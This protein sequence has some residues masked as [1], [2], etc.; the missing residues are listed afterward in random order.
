MK[1]KIVFNAYPASRWKDTTPIGNG[2]LGGAIYGATYDE[3][4]L[5]NHEALYDDSINK[6]IPDISYALADVRRLMDEKRYL[7]ADKYY[8]E[9]LKK[10]EY[11][12]KK[13]AFY[14][15]F[16]LHYIL[17]TE[18]AFTDYA[19]KLDMRTG[20]CAVTYKENDA[21]IVR[22]AFVSQKN[23][24]MLLRIE[25]SKSFDVMFALEPHDVTD[26]VD[27]LG[28]SMEKIKDFTSCSEDKYV[29][30]T[31]ETL[32]G[33]HYSGIFSV[34]ETDG[35][36]T[37]NGR[38]KF[39]KIDMHGT[40]KLSNYLKV[41]NATYI[42]AVLNVSEQNKAFADW[43]LDL[44][45]LKDTYSV[46]KREQID[47]FSQIFDRVSL[48]LCS[49]EKTL[50]NE[51][52]FL[53]SYN[54]KVSAQLIEKM[55]DFGR[56]LL[57]SSSYGCKFP[58]N[59]QGLWNGDY[60]PA[61]A[62]TFFNNENIQ[63]E[64]WQALSGNLSETM[65]PLFDLYDSLKEDYRMN[66]QKLY[67]CRGIL[68]PLFM[69]NQSGKK[70]NLQSHVLYWTGS[71]AWISALYY[72]YYLFTG[73]EEFL[74]NRAYPFMK[75]AALFYED[76]LTLDAE[77]K[78]KSY[79]SNS[80]ENRANGDFEGAGEISVCINATM[81]FALIKELFTNLLTSSRAYS[82]D[83]EKEK[84][85]ED[86]LSRIPEY[87]I[88]E[89]GALQEWLHEDFKDNYHHRH[90][91]HIYPL[92]PGYEIMEETDPE[93]FKAMQIAVEKRL[94]I[95]LKEQT[96]WSFAHMANIF[97][98]LCNGEK[99]KECLDLLLRFCTG[100]NLFTYH[101]DWRN[102]GV[103]LKYMIA[104]QA[105]FQ[106]DANMGFTSA[107]YEMLLY[108]NAK[109][110]KFLPAVPK[111]FSQGKIEGLIA[112][113]GIKVSIEWTEN[114]AEIVVESIKDVKMHVGMKNGRLLQST[115]SYAES[116]YGEGFVLMQFEK[117]VSYQLKFS[118]EHN[119]LS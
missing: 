38:D 57:I 2:R 85:W 89:D 37:C 24:Y 71:S 15:A 48:D 80:P 87:R 42:T 56:Y 91:S 5:I 41:S 8:I 115:A 64:Y 55:A 9:L 101:N 79:P 52:L 28:N 69:D 96:G 114:V 88:N 14:P 102:M 13:G 107:I 82:L 65:L 44:D 68:L 72:D 31:C 81:D 99:A 54:G 106:I 70:D 17:E 30:S 43:K 75:E 93:L 33:L 26:M 66:A 40:G 74:V 63:M 113:G 6:D 20:I 27:Y 51:Q 29:Y 78:L 105:P 95:G 97:V 1:E 22:E 90:Q 47:S 36:I 109:M 92:F 46:M 67:G 116:E 61:W 110:L 12:A 118:R 111:E 58:A 10:A 18:G 4:I 45:N 19:R 86:I 108:S 112:R 25:K 84:I 23:G 83:A 104:K 94:V 35:T 39:K 34:I 77:G 62:C 59:L 11:Y 32:G 3:R 103:T 50:S 49:D 73:D 76:F 53:D 7:E 98:R 21:Q 119:E 100:T 117:G 16:D 60:T